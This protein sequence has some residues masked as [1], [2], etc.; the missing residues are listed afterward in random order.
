MKTP[1]STR[2]CAN[3]QEQLPYKKRAR[4]KRA[5]LGMQ[6]GL[7]TLG[8]GRMRACYPQLQRFVSSCRN[9]SN[10]QNGR[11][12]S[13]TNVVTSPPLNQNACSGAEQNPVQ[14]SGDHDIVAAGIAAHK[15]EFG[16]VH[17]ELAKH[18][19]CTESPVAAQNDLFSNFMAHAHRAR[20]ASGLP[21]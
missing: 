3:D 20:V 15:R 1:A 7:A 19:H 13:P 21:G 8:G 17:N 14:R 5:R 12:P 9:C 4:T 6:V 18:P 2:F 16:G 10:P 11:E